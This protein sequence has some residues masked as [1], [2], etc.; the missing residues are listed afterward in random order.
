M[1]E[2]SDCYFCESV[3]EDVE[4]FPVIPPNTDPPTDRQ[5][6][7][8]LCPSCREK[9]ERVTDPIVAH[10]DPAAADRAGASAGV[11]EG[12]S[13]EF[14]GEVGGSGAGTP[15][16]TTDG[17]EEADE[18][19]ELPSETRKILQLLENREFPVDREEIGAVAAKA[20]GVDTDDVD[21]VF[22]TLIDQGRLLDD[23]GTLHKPD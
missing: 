10:L 2:F 15:E 16:D 18:P 6:R 22:D 9:L 12:T 14:I 23:D 3:E 20:Y 13:M 5:R 11:D 17:T 7:V 4:Q 8:V 19:V 21:V 1:V